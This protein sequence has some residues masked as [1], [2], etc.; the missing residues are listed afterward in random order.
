MIFF[1][2]LKIQKSILIFFNEKIDS[3]LKKKYSNFFASEKYLL[4]KQSFC[5]N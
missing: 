1:Y 2:D 3:N 5:K 4:L